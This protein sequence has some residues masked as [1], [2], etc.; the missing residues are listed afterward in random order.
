MNTGSCLINLKG[1]LNILTDSERKVAEY[2]LEH[3]MDVL[4]DTVTELA[5]KADV[6]DA[7]VVRFCRSVGYKG[8]QDLK[9]NLAQ[10]AIAPYKHLNTSLEKDDTPE[11]ISEKV[12]RSEI[13]TLEET[14]HILDWQE[15]EHV[16]TAIYEA[17][18][19][20]FFGMGG[21]ALVAADAMHKF[22]K[23]GICCMIQMDTDVQSMQSSVL[24]KGDVAF[25][26]SHSGY[27]RHVIECLQNAKEGGATVIGLT[28]LG[29]SPMQKVCDHLLATSSGRETIFKSESVAARI[30]QLSVIDSL[31][32]ILSCK[33]YDE[34]N[35]AIQ[36]TRR[37]TSGGKY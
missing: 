8:Y 17:K 1:K 37:A 21:S 7:T 20:V 24:K 34:A 23:I 31:V 12:I 2:I 13:D 32:A 27:N 16:A 5:K 35:D 30:A 36:K 9:I 15:M 11:R 6:S 33:N 14:L 26:I 10:D 25:G 18:R 28:T 22:L 19:V 4:N 3:Y 29:D